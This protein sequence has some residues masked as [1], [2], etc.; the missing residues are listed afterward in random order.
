MLT[1]C[2]GHD[3]TLKNVEKSLKLFLLTH[4]EFRVGKKFLFVN[5]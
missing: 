1:G 4:N 3:F 2:S 5:S